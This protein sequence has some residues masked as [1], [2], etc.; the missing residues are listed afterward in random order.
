VCFS[1]EINPRELL[2][3]EIEKLMAIACCS[4]CTG[5]AEA[6]VEARADVAGARG[7]LCRLSLTLPGFRWTS[8]L[9]VK[10]SSLT[11][12]PSISCSR[13]RR[14]CW[15]LDARIC[16]ACSSPCLPIVEIATHASCPLPSPSPLRQFLLHCH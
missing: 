6:R 9:S 1:V 12:C 13:H 11:G 2:N 8:P 3:S 4:L 14:P 15:P 7:R 5:A 10:T 16:G